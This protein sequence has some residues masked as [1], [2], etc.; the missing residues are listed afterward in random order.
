MAARE[1]IANTLRVAFLVCLVCALVVS[2]AAVTLQPLQRENRQLHRQVNILRTAG[3]YLP[4][5]D[6]RAA[7]RAI[8]RRFVELET[9]RYVERSDD[10]DQYLAARD[11]AQGRRL[12]ED[13]AGIRH[14]PK[15]AEVYLARNEA[16]ELTR[17]I[18]P[19]HGYGLWS[20]M[21]GFIALEPDL[22]TVAGLSFYEHGETPGL[23]GEIDNPRW[24]QRWVGKRLYDDEGRL[25][26]EVLK[27][28]VPEGDAAAAHKVDG[29]SGA[30]LTT[31]GVNNLVRFW[32]G[33]NGFGPYLDGLRERLAAGGD[34]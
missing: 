4:G 3:M 8:E 25:A 31:R 34:E 1:S 17:V 29:I 13:P 26:I 12:A 21:Y 9:G 2:T 5:L 15:V 18:L 23:G 11:P 30:T 28:A 16:G 22:D 19:I 7:F 6:A 33:E 24:Q 10:Y 32:L 14:L 20:T 27:G